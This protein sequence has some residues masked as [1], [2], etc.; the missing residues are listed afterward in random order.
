V[1]SLTLTDTVPAAILNA[2]FTPSAGSY[3][4][5]TGAWT[6][7]SLATGQSV[8]LTLAGT[9]NPTVTGSLAN[10]ATVAPPAGVT[11]PVAGND[12]S[13][14]TDAL[15]PQADLGVVKTDGQTSAIPGTPISYTMTVTNNGPSTV[16]SLTLT[17]AVPAAILSPVFTPSAGSYNS[18]TGA[19]TGLNL[20]TGQAVT[21]TLAGTVSPTA[22]GTLANTATVT[23]PAGVTDPVAGN[24]SSTDT[25]AL[26]PRADLGVVK[27]DAQTTAVPGLPIAYVITVTNNGPSTV[28]ALTLTDA[29]PAAILNPVFTPSTG[30]YNSVTGAW[31]GLNLATGQNITLALA[32]TVSPSA[33]GTLVNTATVAPP[34]G[35][36]DSVPGND[37]STDTDTLT[38]EADLGVT[39]TDSPDPVTGVQ[40]LT[41]TIAVTNAGPS[42]PS[43][44]VTQTLPG[45]V[46]FLSASGTGWSCGE[47]GGVVTCT[48]PSLATG[49]APAITVQVTAPP[50]GPTLT[51]TVT[52]SSGATDPVPANNSDTEQTTVTAVP[53]ADLSV[54]LDDGGVTAL[55][56]RTLRYTILVRN[57]GPDPV[58]GATVTD[59]FPASL[60]GLA[61]TCAA[62]A[63]SS[64]TAAGTGS[65]NDAAVNL[66]TSGT[67][68]YTATGLVVYGT[69]GPITDTASASS[70][71]YD[72][73]TAN[74]SATINTPVDPDRIFGDGFGSGGGSSP[75][76]EGSPSA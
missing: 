60:S 75:E 55:W 65:I 57:L 19:W 13:T 11:D 17:D 72:P 7:L 1:T 70:T 12:S 50:V 16:P 10:T 33:T 46:T 58:T 62:S 39:L 71:V 49:A 47:A 76:E 44:V 67:A 56:N 31:T 14:D 3:N 5:G 32:G 21:L 23:P 61:W 35:V 59:A 73:N 2:V 38:P 45:S 66:L 64:C 27:T 40:T 37:S 51:S 9:V 8:T 29:V 30:S 53:V 6:G 24:D 36:T 63:G 48:R 68:T 18:G 26:T 74:N 34:A 28:G 54:T 20:A 22:T 52:V 4:S 43:V 69:A 15:T 25:D 42:A 41:Y